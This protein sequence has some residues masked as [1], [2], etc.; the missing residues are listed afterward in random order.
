MTPHPTGPRRRARLLPAFAGTALAAALT[1][2]AADDP[3]VGAP[4]PTT[5]AAAE[6]SATPVPTGS[7]RPMGHIHAVAQDPDGTV[8]LATHGGLFR[9]G[10]DGPVP[11]GPVV[12]LMGFAV[13]PDGGYL[14]SG[15]PGP[16]TDL[17]QPVGLVRSDDRG[18]TWTEVSRAGESDF[19]GLT[20]GEGLVA[21]YDGVLR[22]GTDG[23][24]WQERDVPGDPYLLAASPDGGRLLVTTPQGLVATEDAGRSWTAVET[25]AVLVAVDWADDDT[26]VGVDVSGLLHEST[27]RGATWRSGQ[28][29][30]GAASTLH[31]GR[32]AAGD[33][34][35]LAVVG[36]AVVSTTDLGATT[37]RLF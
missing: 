35:V 21:G 4:A 11:V 27:D 13:A 12:D 15:H 22:V 25:P 28:R 32:N 19:H 8:L 5:S 33:L 23:T 26:V 2:C 36:D 37:A 10:A 20:A 30:V 9:V 3:Q 34:R 1:G 29:P 16:G 24:D 17:A 6:A 14:A 18:V 7:P 31:A